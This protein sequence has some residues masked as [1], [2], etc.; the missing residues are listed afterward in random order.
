MSA[1]KSLMTNVKS[2]AKSMVNPVSTAAQQDLQF[3]MNTLNILNTISTDYT[4]NMNMRKYLNIP[5]DQG[6]YLA[7][8]DAVVTELLR[9][10]N[11]TLKTLFKI[12]ND[13][14][15][16]SLHSRELNQQNIDLQLRVAMLQK[17]NDDILSGKNT[18]SAIGGD[19]ASGQ[20]ELKKTF[21]LAP[22]Y[23]YYIYLYGLPAFG[24]GFEPAKLTLLSTILKKYGIDPFK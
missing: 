17:K 21:K 9:I 23:S 5:D 3:S 16:G 4:G 1:S 18:H 7:L 12:T 11:T 14:L 15:V 2:A 20:F 13:G 10:K 6:A 19:S 22:L 24:V 8:N